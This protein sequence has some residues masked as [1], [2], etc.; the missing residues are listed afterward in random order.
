[1]NEKY[2]EFNEQAEL[3]ARICINLKQIYYPEMGGF[4]SYRAVAEKLTQLKRKARLILA[5]MD[6]MEML[7]TL[8]TFSTQ[9]LQ[10]ILEND[11]REKRS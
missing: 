3:G 6:E 4:E 11:E 10:D 9:D 1:M 2:T 5:H 8:R 7:K